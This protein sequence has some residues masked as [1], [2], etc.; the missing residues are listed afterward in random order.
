MNVFTEYDVASDV[1]T[2]FTYPKYDQEV[3]KKYKI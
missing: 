1:W 2:Q 3:T